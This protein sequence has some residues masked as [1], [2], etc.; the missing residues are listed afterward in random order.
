MTPQA[1]T[2]PLYLAATIDLQLAVDWLADSNARRP[3]PQRLLMA[4]LFLKAVAN[5]LR[6]APELNGLLVDG[7]CV[8]NDAIHLG[9][10]VSARA[11]GFRMPVVSDADRRSLE[12]LM[13]A[14]RDARSQPAAGPPVVATFTVTT[15]GEQGVQAVFPAVVPP[16]LAGVGFGR[17]SEQ[18]SAVDGVIVCSHVVTA[19]LATDHR[20]TDSHRGARF[21][22]S[23][24]A[25]LQ[26]PG[27][28]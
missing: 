21:L 24:D 9:V 17:V 11:G 3:A 8:P 1:V 19:T 15:L 13:R 7:R 20:V 23:L 6:D 18:P 10:V 14:L 2:A 12:D 26:R 22:A 4:A 16:Q 28:L 5:A 25:W 27:A